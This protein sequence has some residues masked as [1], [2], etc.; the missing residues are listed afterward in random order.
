MNLEKYNAIFKEIFSVSDT[1]LN[2]DF[3]ADNVERWDSVNHIQLITQIE[4]EFGIELEMDDMTDFISYE[5]GIE[6]LKKYG[7]EM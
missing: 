4:D 1:E 2:A 7:I 3:V 5:G 6:I